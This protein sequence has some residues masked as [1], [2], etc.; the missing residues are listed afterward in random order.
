MIDRNPVTDRNAVEERFGGTIA[1]E[2]IALFY[3][4]SV[5]HGMYVPNT[6]PNSIDDVDLMAVI[7]PDVRYYF[8]LRDFGSRGTIERAW[9]EYDVVGYEIRKYIRL[10]EQGNPNVLC[11]LW[12]NPEH[13][14]HTLPVFHRI[15]DNRALFACRRVYES[16]KGY[17]TSM[18]HRMLS[19]KYDGYMGSK[20]KTIVDKFGYDVKAASHMIRLLRMGAEFLYTGAMMVDRRMAGDAAELRTIKLGGYDRATVDRMAAQAE[21]YLDEAYAVS[22]LPDYVDHAAID[23]L[24]VRCVNEE[25]VSRGEI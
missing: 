11:S 6:D 10:L 8:G 18:R 20:R 1:Y 9:D 7:V 4:G 16:V 3:R 15:Q 19:G 17:A 14:V 2:T 24:A 21:Q 5:A 13:Y 23:A 12:L 25:L 22:P